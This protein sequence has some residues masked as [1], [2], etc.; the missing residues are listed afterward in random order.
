[1][2]LSVKTVVSRACLSSDC[3]GDCFPIPEDTIVP[4]G[5]FKNRM[6]VFHEMDGWMGGWMGEWVDE[7]VDLDGCMDGWIEIDRLTH[8]ER[9]RQTDRQTDRQIDR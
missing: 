8:R 1:M 2:S 6:S 3:F 4:R 5:L 9:D 7:W